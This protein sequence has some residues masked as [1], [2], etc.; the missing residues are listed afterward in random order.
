[1]HLQTKKQTYVILLSSGNLG[2]DVNDV[3]K[4]IFGHRAI[5]LTIFG[6]CLFLF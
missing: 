1:L 5:E 6:A 4:N 2:A 3:M